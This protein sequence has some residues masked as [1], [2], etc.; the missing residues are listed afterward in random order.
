MKY[1]H[2]YLVL[3]SGEKLVVSKSK[4]EDLLEKLGLKK[5]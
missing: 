2:C 1:C 3:N 4:K 5:E